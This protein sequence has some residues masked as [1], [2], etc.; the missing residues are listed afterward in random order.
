MCTR[1]FRADLNFSVL[2]MVPGF[3]PERLERG[4]NLYA[5]ISTLW[6]VC[7][8]GSEI[9]KCIVLRYGRLQY[10]CARVSTYYYDIVKSANS[11]WLYTHQHWS[12]QLLRKSPSSW[13]NHIRRPIKLVCLMQKCFQVAGDPMQSQYT[14]A[15][16][17]RTCCERTYD[18]PCVSRRIWYT[19]IHVFHWYY[20]F[21]VYV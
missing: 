12:V 19:F 3:T 15:F 13:A 5:V 21:V 10:V 4:L 14:H 18:F 17:T 16:N 2:R 7:A 11:A 20:R 8:L 1:A 9:I 6:I